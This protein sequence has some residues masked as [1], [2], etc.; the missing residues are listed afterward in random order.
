MNARAFIVGCRGHHLDDAEVSFLRDAQPWGLILFRRNCDAPEQV[1]ALVD[2]FRETVGWAA[3]VLID[4]EGGRVQRLQPPR[5]RAFPAARRFGLLYQQDRAE[6]LRLTRLGARLIAADLAALGITVDCLPVLDLGR[7]ETH[8]VIG[9]RAYAAE[10]RAVQALG[11]AA[12]E[13]LLEGGVLPVL[14]HIP[15]HG[16][17]T[18]D[19]HEALPVV[20]ASRAQLEDDFAPFRA[21]SDMPLAMTAHVLYPALDSERPATTSP[22]IIRDVIRGAIGFDGLLMSD[23]LSMKALTG[24]FAERTAAVFAAG[25]DLALHCNGLLDEM[26][27]VAA[28]APRL[29]GRALQRAQAALDR[30]ARPAPIDVEAAWRELEASLSA[31]A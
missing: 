13:G 2:Q 3:P 4:Q 26:E 25:C 1:R 18:A 19:S 22:V 30:L 21:L 31:L 11:R 24:G 16:R 15:G 28:E 10:P 27:A 9:D 14:K 8:A 23:D 7:P 5:W 17:A 29:Q 6:G 20:S 12:A